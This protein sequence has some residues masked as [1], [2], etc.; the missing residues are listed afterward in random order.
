MVLWNFTG[1]AESSGFFL[2]HHFP[3]ESDEGQPAFSGEVFRGLRLSDQHLAWAQEEVSK[4]LLT[5]FSHETE[6]P[7]NKAFQAEGVVFY[8]E[9]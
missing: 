9:G 6:R 7:R 2:F 1:Q 3:D 4:Q 8:F 5:R